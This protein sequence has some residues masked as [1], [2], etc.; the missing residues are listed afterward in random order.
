MLAFTSDI[1]RPLCADTFLVMIGL[2]ATPC[3]SAP[4]TC[5]GSH[6]P[7][8]ARGAPPLGLAQ[9]ST[10]LTSP[11]PHTPFRTIVQGVGGD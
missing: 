5:L 11:Y 6:A 7:L 10:L 1:W 9:M 8:E 4:L 2:W 3:L